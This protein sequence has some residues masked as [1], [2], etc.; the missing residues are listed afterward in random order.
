MPVLID[1]AKTGTS[2]QQA[3]IGAGLARAALAC[4]RNDP[5]Y[6]AMIQEAVANSGLAP[7]ITAFVSAS[8]DV[9]TAAI[10][11]AAAAGGIGGG[12]GGIGGGGAAGEL[13]AAEL[14]QAAALPA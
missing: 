8:N 12:A 7:I 10:S 13:V 3:A 2:A 9:Q 6:A 1:I 4:S 14:Q 11:G 5:D